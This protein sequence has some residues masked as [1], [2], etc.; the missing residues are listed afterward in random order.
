MLLAALF[1]ALT[2]AGGAIR[3]P[4][5]LGYIT[6]H[7]LFVYLAGSLLGSKTGAVSQ[8]LFLAIGLM[9]FP[10]FSNGGGPGYIVHYTFGYLAGFPIAAWVIG[11]LIE[12][13]RTGQWSN[14]LAANSVGCAIILLTGVVYLY[15]NLRYIQKAPISWTEA[16]ISGVLIFLPGELIK[17]GITTSL[18]QRMASYLKA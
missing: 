15:I 14:I 5:P 6:F 2:A 18:T 11:K 1:A 17:I 9:G 16:L 10:V 8:I 4:A 12:K 7:T 3:I 13:N